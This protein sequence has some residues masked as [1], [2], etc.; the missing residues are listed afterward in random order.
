M[1]NTP[2]VSDG[3]NTNNRNDVGPFP[4]L[5]VILSEPGFCNHCSWPCKTQ[6]VIF[7]NRKQKYN[8]R[9][10]P[11]ADDCVLSFRKMHPQ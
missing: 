7:K 11:K 10:I 2:G 4:P 6:N 5:E 1:K 9:F 3:D 8:I